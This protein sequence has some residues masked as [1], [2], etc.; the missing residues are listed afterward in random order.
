MDQA[1]QEF[2]DER[3]VRDGSVVI[4]TGRVQRWFFSSGVITA[5]LIE[6]GTMPQDRERLKILVRC[7]M[8]AG[9]RDWTRCGGI[10]S[11]MQVVGR[12]EERSLETSSSVI[13]SNTES[14]PED[15]WEGIMWT[16]GDC[17]AISC[18]I[19]SDMMPS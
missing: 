19:P 15:V 14:K 16:F 3:E 13:R 6:E 9:E 17:D 5:C 18:R 2:R 1:F 10:G 11:V 7:K 4:R 8:T 12:A